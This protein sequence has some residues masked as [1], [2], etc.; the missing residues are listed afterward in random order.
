LIGRLL[1]IA[2]LDMSAPQVPMMDLDLADVLSQVVRNAEFESKEPHGAIRLTSAGNCIVRG[3][4]ELLHSGI[5]N[6]I[7]N[8][9]RYTDSGTSVEICLEP[10]SSSS[11]TKI[12]LAV[13]D[14]GPGVPEAELENIFQPFY[15]LADA[16]DRQSGGTGLGLAIADRVVRIHGGTIRAENATPRG[17]RIEIVL[18]QSSLRESRTA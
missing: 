17:L 2:K 14:Y 5:E 10:E 9:I 7:R 13:R 11:G 6:V 3:N 12:R 8:A 1:T 16:R 18:P 15:R 4:A